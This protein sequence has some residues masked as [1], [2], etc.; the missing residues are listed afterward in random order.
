[1]KEII[2]QYKNKRDSKKDGN[3]ALC[4]RRVNHPAFIFCP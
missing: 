2:T 1:M 4:H 3:R